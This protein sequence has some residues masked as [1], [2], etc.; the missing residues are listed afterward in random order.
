MSFSP[1]KSIMTTNEN[2]QSSKFLEFI[3]YLLF[4]F[5]PLTGNIIMVLFLVLS[6]EFSV[7][8]SAILVVIPAFMFPF[9]I[10]QLF[11]GAISDIKGR[12]PVLIIGLILFGVAMLLAALSI[13][14]EIFLVANFLAGI[15]FGLINPVLMALMTDITSPSNIPKKMGFL[16]ASANL[17]VGLGPLIASQMILIGW[18]SIYIVFVIIVIIGLTFFITTKRPPQKIPDDPG[19]KIFF[20]HLS[21]ELRRF[22][23]VVMVV[24]AVLISHTY[25]AINIWTSKELSGPVSESLIGVVLGIAG[26]GAA[27]TSIITGNTIKKR[28]IRIPLIFGIILLFLSLAMFIIIGDITKPE[29]FFSL[30]IGWI[31]SGLAGGILFP[32]ITYYSQVLSPERRGVLAGLVT[33]GYFIGIALVPTTLAPLSDMFG[34]TGVYISILGISILF[35]LI[36]I[37]LYKL[38][39][40]VVIEEGV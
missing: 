39:S 24:S 40:R 38:A 8:P 34:I 15:G 33:A 16:G 1:D 22:V 12:F 4:L 14:L 10:T 21:K 5:G 7:E 29:V 25:L 3:I 9:A 35:T 37:L 23:V 13:S 6:G 28:G 11:S 27:I 20:S 17:G 18:R 31:L 26:V 30:A 19:L 32:A 2:Q 36:L